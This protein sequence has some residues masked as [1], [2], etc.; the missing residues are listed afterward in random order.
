M[1][2]DTPTSHWKLYGMRIPK[3]VVRTQFLGNTASQQTANTAMRWINECTSSHTK[4][5]DQNGSVLPTRLIDV[6]TLRLCQTAGKLEAFACLSHCWGQGNYASSV[7][8]TIKASI[9]SMKEGLPWDIVP[10]T[11]RDA[12]HFTRS[13]GIRYFLIDSLCIV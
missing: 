13:L 5:C 3:A 9:A 1:L 6:T 2:I 8:R 10:R 7:L 12:I 11:F 4:Y